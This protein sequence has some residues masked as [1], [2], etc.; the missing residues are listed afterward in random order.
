VLPFFV[1]VVEPAE[2]GRISGVYLGKKKTLNGK[3][4]S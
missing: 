3:L 4:E 1:M 2:I